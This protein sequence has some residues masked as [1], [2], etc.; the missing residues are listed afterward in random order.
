[1]DNR[2]ILPIISEMIN[3]INNLVK[4]MDSSIVFFL[5]RIKKCVLILKMKQHIM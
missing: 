4:E 2:N 3:Q 5:G 1:M